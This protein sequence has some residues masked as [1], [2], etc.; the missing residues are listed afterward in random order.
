MISSF[1]EEMDFMVIN[2]C[3]DVSSLGLRDQI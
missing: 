1:R 2:G 3:V